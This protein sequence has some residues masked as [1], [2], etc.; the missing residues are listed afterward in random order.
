MT[1][2]IS[3]FRKTLKRNILN[4]SPIVWIFAGLTRSHSIC[5]RHTT[6]SWVGFFSWHG[7]N[8]QT[9]NRS[10]NTFE[11]HH[12][13]HTQVHNI[14]CNLLFL[15][16]RLGTFFGDLAV[17]NDATAA[18]RWK[19][20]GQE[21]WCWRESGPQRRSVWNEICSAPSNNRCSLNG[22]EWLGLTLNWG[23]QLLYSHSK[24]YK[25]PFFLTN[26]N[27]IH[28]FIYWGR[29]KKTAAKVIHVKE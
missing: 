13:F 2:K 4:L 26:E 21:T 1:K 8:T 9:Q 18:K 25:K 27:R 3:R 7:V 10:V 14:S 20:S 17:R 24:T 11:G 6:T 28:V 19:M 22:L 5:I 12:I 29:M 23:C 15:F 16:C